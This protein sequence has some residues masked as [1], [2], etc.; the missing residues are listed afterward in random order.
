MNDLLIVFIGLGI[1]LYIFFILGTSRN[2]IIKGFN[3][4]LWFLFSLILPPIAFMAV[5]F[6]KSDSGK[7]AKEYN[8]LEKIIMDLSQPFVDLAHTSRA[9]LGVNI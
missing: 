3:G 8:F 1:M 6:I 5:I 4:V 2:A 9:L 7:E